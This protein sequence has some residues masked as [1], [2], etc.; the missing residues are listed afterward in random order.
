LNVELNSTITVDKV[1][2]TMKYQNQ[3]G[4]GY[5]GDSSLQTFVFDP[6][7]HPAEWSVFD[8]MRYK[9]GDNNLADES[10]GCKI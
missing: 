7:F 5:D 3:Y 8:G 2:R 4:Q 1:A 6:S 10:W 9:A